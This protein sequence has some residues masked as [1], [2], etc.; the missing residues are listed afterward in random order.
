LNN[1]QATYE[2]IQ[3][4]IKK[5]YDRNVKSCWIAHAKEI[6]GLNPKKSHLRM[7]KRIHLCPEDKLSWMKDAFKHYK[8]I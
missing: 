1:H 7:G 3:N 4:Y 2:E 8:M 6:Y 5:K